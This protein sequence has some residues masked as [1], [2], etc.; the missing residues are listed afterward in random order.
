MRFE[1]VALFLEAVTLILT[2]NVIAYDYWKKSVLG[3]K[4][5]PYFYLAK[6]VRIWHEI[7]IVLGFD[8]YKSRHFMHIEIHKYIQIWQTNNYINCKFVTSLFISLICNVHTVIL[9]VS[10]VT[11]ISDKTSQNYSTVA[12]DRSTFSA[13]KRIWS[14]GWYVSNVSIIF[15]APCLFIHHLLCVLLH[16]VAF[17]CIFQN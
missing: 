11:A 13:M 4:Y 3:M 5:A 12:R 17:L 8:V 14:E 16:F 6:Y 1:Y 2:M 10:R 9:R 15:D 7:Y